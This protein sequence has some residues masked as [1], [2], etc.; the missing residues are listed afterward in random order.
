M[1]NCKYELEELNKQYGG[2]PKF[3]QAKQL[4]ENATYYLTIN[5]LPGALVSYSCAAVLFNVLKETKQIGFNGGVGE[6]QPPA[7]KN[8]TN[9]GNIPSVTPPNTPTNIVPKSQDHLST[10]L[11]CCLKAIENLQQKVSQ[12]CSSNKQK[13]DEEEKPWDKICTKIQPLVFKKGGSD[14]I[15]FQDV[16]G[17]FI[18]KKLMDESLIKPLQFPNVYP[19]ASRGLLIYGPPGTGKTY[20]VKAAV[21]ELQK[22]DPHV[23]ILFFAPSPGDFKGKYVGE[24]EKKIEEIFV[25]ASKAACTYQTDICKTSQKKY[26]S[27]IFMDEMD[28]IAPDRNNDPTGLAVNSVNTLLQMMDGIKS[29][30]NITVIAATNYPWNLD[31]AILRRFDS[32]IFIDVP[33]ERDLLE[34][35]DIQMRAFINIHKNVSDMCI[36]NN[37]NNSLVAGCQL[38]CEQK[39]K[40]NVLGTAPYS[41]MKF[42]FFEEMKKQKDN[43]IKNIVSKM[44]LQNFSNS[45]LSTFMKTAQRKAGENALNANLFY[46]T[47]LLGYIRNPGEEIYVSSLSF[48]KDK[49]DQVKKSIEIINKLLDNKAIDKDFYFIEIPD[50]ITIDFNGFVYYN[51]KCL[52]CKPDIILDDPY[53]KDVYIKGHPKEKGTALNDD[54]YMNNILGINGNSI[55]LIMT[56]DNITFF[57]N[58]NIDNDK[59]QIFP[60]AMGILETVVTPLVNA[61]NN[62][63]ETYNKAKRFNTTKATETLNKYTN[64]VVESELFTFDNDKC[65][66]NTAF[67]KLAEDVCIINDET[68]LKYRHNL[69]F[70]RWLHLKKCYKTLKKFE[71]EYLNIYTGTI[72][73][74]DKSS[75]K[76]EIISIVRKDGGE[77]IDVCID[78]EHIYIENVDYLS[79]IDI[80]GFQDNL[81]IGMSD[82]DLGIDDFKKEILKKIITTTATTAT[83]GATTKNENK[84]LKIPFQLFYNLFN[85]LLIM[86]QKQEGDKNIDIIQIDPNNPTTNNTCKLIQMLIDDILNYKL[87]VGEEEQKK[88]IDDLFN[89]LL[90]LGNNSDINIINFI[91][92][93]AFHNYLLRNPTTIPSPPSPPAPSPASEPASAPAPAPE[94]NNYNY[95]DNDEVDEYEYHDVEGG[96]AL[97]KSKT[98]SKSKKSSKSKTNS[99]SKKTA[100]NKTFKKYYVLPKNNDDNDITNQYGNVH[101]YGGNDMAH[102]IDETF[103]L[104]GK[105]NII[106]GGATTYEKF[107]EWTVKDNIPETTSKNIAKKTAY[108]HTTVNLDWRDLPEY[109]N[110]FST[111]YYSTFGRGTNS[112]KNVLEMLMKKNVLLST[113]FKRIDYIGFL[114]DSK[115]LNKT[116]SDD[117]II[118][119]YKTDTTKIKI[120]WG[121]INT[122]TFIDNFKDILSIFR[123]D[124]QFVTGIVKAAK[125]IFEN[126]VSAAVAL[127]VTSGVVA[128]YG[129]NVDF[130]D[131]ALLLYKTAMYFPEAI[132]TIIIGVVKFIYDNIFANFNLTITMPTILTNLSAFLLQLLNGGW[133]ALLSGGTYIASLLAGGNIVFYI[134]AFTIFINLAAWATKNNITNEQI[135]NNVIVNQIYTMVRDIKV[136]EVEDLNINP[137]TLF[138]KILDKSQETAINILPRI[139]TN[140]FNINN[141]LYINVPKDNSLMVN[142]KTSQH[143]PYQAIYM[144]SSSSK[145]SIVVNKEKLINVEIPLTAFYYALINT[146]ST[147]PKELADD[148]K[149]YNQDKDAFMLKLK[150]KRE[151]N[152]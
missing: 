39:V 27:I 84:F 38:E 46:S 24:T 58:K 147:Y 41:N 138:G 90:E 52:L 88:K 63:K 139:I 127:G 85:D 32:Q 137:C 49:R 7:I 73:A 26:R 128:K 123:G 17:L 42:T 95:I 131:Q 2:D 122:S 35:L 130:S 144:K 119:R 129:F 135:M 132:Y 28:A 112:V 108:L 76:C 15:F 48:V 80:I 57:E 74:L 126:T 136:F 87:I 62:T 25:C 23:G 106:Y 145:N 64:F 5:E 109:T 4:Y 100:G 65:S 97:S 89:E 151:K 34:L 13:D 118:Q 61:Y 68:F 113:L 71:S 37:N 77:P 82:V 33:T 150:K 12:M 51:R 115:N 79:L 101:F 114:V 120:Y 104:D 9:D 140:P 133:T 98:N 142:N 105:N 70:L 86:P 91:I 29:K 72:E 96:T 141:S 93:R 18:E 21:N 3:Q 10:I 83:T 134:L 67:E 149:Q 31:S 47:R 107:L 152:T 56:F 1:N 45:D 125:S 8:P 22:K 143:F 124:F 11:T 102:I 92:Q 121:Y 30:P 6:S 40:S 94:Q 117:L 103:E 20:L 19:A 14:C 60:K 66:L 116:E 111:L 16:A 99:K 54:F 75:E 78:K 44:V 59:I 81:D 50:I 69:N 53:I 36:N 148:L 55:D 146:K 43:E 110:L